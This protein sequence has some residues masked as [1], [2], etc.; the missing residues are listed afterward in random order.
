MSLPLA[1]AILLVAARSLLHILIDRRNRMDGSRW[2]A[3]LALL[4]PIAAA[5]M[6]VLIVVFRDQ[7]LATVLEAIKLRY[8]VG[9]VISWHQE[10]LRYY[11]ISVVTDDGA[12]TRR[13]PLLLL[14]AGAQVAGAVDLAADGLGIRAHL[15]RQDLGGSGLRTRQPRGGETGEDEEARPRLPVEG[16]EHD[17][18][19]STAVEAHAV[20][21][22]GAEHG[23]RPRPAGEGGAGGAD[24][25]D[26]E[27]VAARS[28]IPV[29][30]DGAG[31]GAPEEK[32]EES[33]AKEPV[34]HGPMLLARTRRPRKLSG[35]R[36]ARRGRGAR[37]AGSGRARRR[38]R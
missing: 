24:Q 37:G 5:G 28:S 36:R 3:T 7:T 1:I 11:F 25:A 26:G 17:P 10:F 6:V 31:G 2:A 14:L 33:G 38:C 4:A 21:V 20:R 12:L 16:A 15:Q 8:S 13:V 19:R 30:R 35:L 29:R 34:A 32:G 18:G 9:P 23:E 27:G 22:R